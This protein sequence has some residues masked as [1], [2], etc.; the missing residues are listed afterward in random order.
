MLK[1]DIKNK[2]GKKVG[3]TELSDAVFGI[4]PNVH[5]MHQVVRAQQAAMPAEHAGEHRDQRHQRV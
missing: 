4:D 2:G 1:V 3:T 5:V